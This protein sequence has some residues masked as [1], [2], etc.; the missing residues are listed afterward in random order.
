MAITQNP[1]IGRAT[2]QAAG[3]IFSTV[4]GKN[5]I[6][7]KAVSV[8]PSNTPRQVA[9]RQAM[10]LVVKIYGALRPLCQIGFRAYSSTRNAYNMFSS[11]A[12]SNAFDFSNWENVIFDPSAL[13]IAKGSISP[14]SFEVAGVDLDSL[15]VTWPSA[16]IGANQSLTD[17]L[18]LAIVDNANNEVLIREAVAARSVGT[19]ALDVSDF[20]NGS[21]TFTV[22]GF[23]ASVTSALVSDSTF[24]E[25]VA[26]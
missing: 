3:M 26:V 5:I 2:G 14:V 25:I 6:R 23:F 1:I 22:L 13:Q 4:K 17:V 12:L 18:Y 10:S 16:V 19:Y 15:T 24:D 7:A 9:Q 20:T 21:G 11:Y 8:K